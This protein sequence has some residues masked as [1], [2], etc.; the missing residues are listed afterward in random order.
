MERYGMFRPAALSWW[1]IRTE[2]GISLA[3][4][5]RGR[6]LFGLR[7]QTASICRERGLIHQRRCT[8][9][10]AFCGERVGVRGSFYPRLLTLRKDQYLLTRRAK[11]AASSPR[12]RGEAR[13]GNAY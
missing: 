3:I 8:P 9:C 1:R 11:S 6:P 4:P 13:E 5:Q 2:R 7:C 12:L 10:P